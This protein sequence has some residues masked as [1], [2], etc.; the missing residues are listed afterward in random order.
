MDELPARD[1]TSVL[2]CRSGGMSA[3]AAEELVEAGYT[4]VLELDGGFN[5]WK[6]E[7]HE[8]GDKR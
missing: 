7:G 3:M 1:E 2:Y 5:A 6:A 8:L 4:N